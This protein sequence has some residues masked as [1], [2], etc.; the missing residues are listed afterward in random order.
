MSVR[1]VFTNAQQQ[2][3]VPPGNVVFREGDD[4]TDMYGVIEGEIELRVAGDLVYTVDAGDI[5]GE[6]ALVD[7]SP[8]SATATATTETTLAVIDRRMFLFLVTETPTFA[9]E[10]MSTMA[11]RLRAYD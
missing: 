1:G 9:L 5:F 8:R 3:T 6:M 4:G 2:L 11:R 7:H 10:V